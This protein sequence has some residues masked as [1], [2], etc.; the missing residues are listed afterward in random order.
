MLDEQEARCPHSNAQKGLK[1]H[2]VPRGN[3]IWMSLRLHP[4]ILS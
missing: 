2:R 4:I 1:V 3:I